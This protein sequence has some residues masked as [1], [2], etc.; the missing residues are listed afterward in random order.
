MNWRAK[1]R[2][3]LQVIVNLIASTTTTKGLNIMTKIDET[4]YEKGIKIT[5]KELAEI[6]F[7]ENGI[8]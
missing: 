5:D 6:N 2:T 8:T 7:M 4:V 3:S 1:P